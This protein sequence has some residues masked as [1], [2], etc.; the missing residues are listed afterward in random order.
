M[1][2]HTCTECYIDCKD[3]KTTH[4]RYTEATSKLLG[5]LTLVQ[6]PGLAVAQSAQADSLLLGLNTVDEQLED[7]LFLC[8]DA[9]DPNQRCAIGDLKI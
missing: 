5:V 3:I 2:H 6:L 7:R 8:V 4:M 9:L 1:K